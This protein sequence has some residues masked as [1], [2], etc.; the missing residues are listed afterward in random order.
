M[1]RALKKPAAS[2][3]KAPSEKGLPLVDELRALIQQS[4]MH[5][6]SA[7]SSGLT[8]LYWGVGQRLSREVLQVERA[9]Y[10][11]QVVETVA[12]HLEVEY[13]RGFSVKN[14]RHMI[15][16]AESFPDTSIVSTLSRQLAWSHFSRCHS[17]FA[18]KI[19]TS[20]GL[21]R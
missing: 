6:A 21:D 13:G 17:A 18:C 10:S 19:G 9:E 8:M 14:L 16:F 5:L 2:K 4:R 3:S 7:V 15:R 20:S 1:K 12:K 11:E